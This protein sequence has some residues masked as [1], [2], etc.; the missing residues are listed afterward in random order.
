MRILLLTDIPPCTNLTA[1]LIINKWCDFLFEEKQEIICATIGDRSLKFEI[2]QDKKEKIKFLNITK[3]RED[4]SIPSHGRKYRSILGGIRSFII[5]NAIAIFQLPQMAFQISKFAKQNK[6][7]LLFVSIQGQTLTRLVRMVAKLS[8]LQYVAQ[9]W[10]PLEWWLKGYEV[11]KIT[12]RINIK[13]FGLVAKNARRFA[14]MSWAMSNIFE[15]DYG[16]TC[17][18][19]LP[20]LSDEEI[21]PKYV[22]K[23][24]QFVIGF[25]GQLYA[26]DEFKILVEALDELGWYYKGKEIIIELYGDKFDSQYEGHEHI[27]FNGYCNQTQLLPLLASMDLLYCPYWFDQE[28]KKA[29]QISFP[30]KLT[31]YLKTRVPVLVHA[32]SYASPRILLEKYKAAYICGSMDKNDMIE[33]LKAVLNDERRKDFGNRGY[34]LFKEYFTYKQMKASLL[35]SLGLLAEKNISKFE[36]LRNIYEK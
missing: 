10:D 20:G 34:K 35:A 1:G 31:S 36:S 13:E 7:D 2:P 16:A 23:R 32:P 29:C 6:A 18:T 21:K 22:G 12:S 5:N 28:Y 25:A 27:R 14:T 17:V 24:K 3:P 26:K 33:L 11:D 4:W 9:T 19:N 30:S 8:G 15:K